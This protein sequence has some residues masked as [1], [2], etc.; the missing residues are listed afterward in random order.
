MNRTLRNTIGATIAIAIVTAAVTAAL[1]LWPASAL[2]D[3]KGT[4][5]GFPRAAAAAGQRMAPPS[6]VAAGTNAD[7]D[8]S[9]AKGSFE[10]GPGGMGFRGHDGGGGVSLARA[11]PRVIQTLAMLALIGGVAALVEARVLRSRPKRA[12]AATH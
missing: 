9:A 8:F 4:P 3:R 7:A 10:G 5:G 12:P 11:V 2:G 1:Q 6:G